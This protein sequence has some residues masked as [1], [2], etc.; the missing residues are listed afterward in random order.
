MKA[1]IAIKPQPMTWL[2]SVGLVHHHDKAWRTTRRWHA[3]MM[4]AASD[5]RRLRDERE[6][7]R[8]PIATALAQMVGDEVEDDDLCALVDAMLP[9]EQQELARLLGQPT[10][11]SV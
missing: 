10:P 2:V 3:A 7:L 9:I 4:R 5:L 6:D 8:V 11:P 1:T